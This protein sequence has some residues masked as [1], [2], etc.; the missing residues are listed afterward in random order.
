[1]RKALAG[2]AAGILLIFGVVV[3][4]ST[5][6]QADD[7]EAF[8][9]V[10]SA[11]MTNIEGLQADMEEA[12]QTPGTIPMINAVKEVM[13]RIVTSFE[14]LDAADPPEH[15]QVQLTP[16]LTLFKD[17]YK[18]LDDKDLDAIDALQ[19]QIESADFD[20]KINQFSHDIELYCAAS[21]SPTPSESPSASPTASE[22][23]SASPTPS[24][25][26]SASPTASASPSPSASPAKSRF[27]TT[28]E[29]VAGQLKELQSQTTGTN[30][31]Q[32][33][34]ALSQIIVL[35]NQMADSEPPADVAAP[36]LDLL[37][38]FNRLKTALDTNDLNALTAL[39]AELEAS[40]P[41]MDT[42]SARAFAAC[43]AAAG[44]DGT[45]STGG[46]G[47]TLPNTGTTPLAMS[48]SVAGLI[49]LGLAGLSGM[50]AVN[51][52]RETVPVGRRT[53]K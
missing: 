17:M 49:A 14:N 45:G 40:T 4:L 37:D 10:V 47:G 25:S 39:Q 34:T 53:A 51:G 5:T 12:L 28:F 13:G 3:P 35:F 2:L 38:L 9:A 33:K 52:R 19:Q 43:P 29:S 6:A 50:A 11:E 24:Q 7:P 8:C 32:I 41:K 22:S 36:L 27:C 21:A 18:A 44:A 42:L 46:K 23:P 48:L 16:L 26:P 15:V 30:L 1:M 20:N 31:S